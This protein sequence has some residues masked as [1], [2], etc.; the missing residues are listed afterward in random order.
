MDIIGSDDIE[1]MEKSYRTAMMNSISG[2]KPLNLLGT[3]SA[4]GKPNLCI[5]SSVFHLGSNPPLLGMILRPP[6]PHNDSLKNIR[7]VNQ[8]TLNNVTAETY[9]NAHQTSASYPSGVSEF[10]QCGFTAYH[11][12]GFKPPFV[13]ESTIKIGLEPVQITDIELNG[14]TLVIGKIT[15]IIADKD[16][17]LPDGSIDHINAGTVAGSGLDSYFLPQLLD[18]LA[19]A[20]P[21]LQVSSILTD[22]S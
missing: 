15:L 3:I 10:E 6:R 11:Q 4:D 2:C 7:S 16:I 18:R 5:I 21:D 22:K 13:K 12:E 1:K 19:Y 20:K 14:T 9:R 17:T 8:Y